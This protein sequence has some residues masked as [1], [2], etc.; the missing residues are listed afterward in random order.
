MFRKALILVLE[1]WSHLSIQ[2]TITPFSIK[3]L[4]QAAAKEVK[5]AKAIQRT[6]KGAAAMEDGVSKEQGS[7]AVVMVKAVKVERAT[8]VQIRATT[9]API[10]VM[11]TKMMKDARKKTLL[12]SVS[13]L[14]TLLALIAYPS[15]SKVS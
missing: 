5:E 8:V 2:R 1:S 9:A 7:S 3:P 14:L 10:K 13:Q 15:V 12:F 11:A 6:A 4:Q